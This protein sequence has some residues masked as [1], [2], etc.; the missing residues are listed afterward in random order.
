MGH[1]GS[2]I[3]A[4]ST[5]FTY[6]KRLLSVL[7]FPLFTRLSAGN[8]VEEDD[9][10]ECDADGQCLLWHITWHE[11]HALSA[12]SE[13]SAWRCWVRTFSGLPVRAVFTIPVLAVLERVALFGDSSSLTV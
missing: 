9:L 6:L 2:D 1:S 5:H 12:H 10:S 4:I 13:L 7:S 3:T 11:T 8:F